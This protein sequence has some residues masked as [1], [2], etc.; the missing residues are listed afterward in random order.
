M[1]QTAARACQKARSKFRPHCSYVWISDE[2]LRTTFSSFAATCAPR[3]KRYVSNVPGPLEARKRLARRRMNHL[4]I[5]RE[6][7]LQLPPPPPPSPSSAWD[8]GWFNSAWKG[9]R[10]PKWK[11]EPPDPPHKLAPESAEGL[12]TR[13]FHLKTTT[14]TDRSNSSNACLADAGYIPTTFRGTAVAAYRGN[15]NAP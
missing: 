10:E 2:L 14:K 11:W 9:D 5:G 13:L 6:P 8:L 3:C 15:A 12:G 1:L 7:G 4:S